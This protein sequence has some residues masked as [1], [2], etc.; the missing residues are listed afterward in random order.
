[1]VEILLSYFFSWSFFLFIN[2]HL[3]TL[4]IV[5]R[6]LKISCK[7]FGGDRLMGC[8]GLG[9]FPPNFYTLAFCVSGNLRGS[10]R[11]FS[12]SQRRT[13][14]LK[15]GGR[16]RGG[17]ISLKMISFCEILNNLSKKRGAKGRRRPPP[18]CIPVEGWG[19]NPPIRPLVDRLQSVCKRS[20]EF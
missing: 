16:L 20:S 13:E 4:A 3:C 11:R 6:T 5:S 18:C 15:G 17:R 7:H 2:S 1:M 14:K 8:R 10:D 19:K 9:I 12:W